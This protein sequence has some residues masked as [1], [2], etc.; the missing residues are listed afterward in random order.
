M[1]DCV[2]NHSK[3]IAKT[4]T[5]EGKKKIFFTG[6]KADQAIPNL[7]VAYGE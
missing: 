7:F 1:P 4:L 2:N 5:N 3:E 6:R